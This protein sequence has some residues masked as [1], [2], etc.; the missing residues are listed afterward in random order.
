MGK[1]G[2][3]AV[4]AAKA[5]DIKTGTAVWY[6]SHSE[7]VDMSDEQKTTELRVF[8]VQGTATTPTYEYKPG[9]LNGLHKAGTWTFLG[10]MLITGAGLL[11]PLAGDHPVKVNAPIVIGSIGMVTGIVLAIIGNAKMRSYERKLG[12]EMPPV[13]YPSADGV[14]CVGPGVVP[15]APAAQTASYQQ[16]AAAVQS[17]TT[18]TRTKDEPAR[19]AIEQLTNHFANA[20]KQAATSP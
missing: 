5:V 6:Y 4:M 17:V 14:L 3:E 8:P 9:G 16:P 12:T 15:A 7:F 2:T 11:V 18:V 13:T 1:N 20:I 19:R 10:G